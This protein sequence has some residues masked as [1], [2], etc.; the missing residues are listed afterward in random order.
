MK[1]ATIPLAEPNEAGVL[2]GYQLKRLWSR[3]M[4]QRQGLPAHAGTEAQVEQAEAQ[5]SHAAGEAARADAEAIVWRDALAVLTGQAPGA[6]DG[7]PVASAVDGI[8]LPPAQVAIGDPGAMLAR[9]PD[10]RAAKA[11]YAAAT[12]DVGEAEARRY[13]GISLLGLIGVGGSSVSNLITSGQGVAILMPR[14][15]WDF[16]DLGRVRAGVRNARA[17]REA[18]LAAYDGRVLAGL[19]DAEA[20]LARFGAAREGALRA[21][22]GAA[23]TEAIATLEQQRADAGVIGRGDAIAARISA[24]EAVLG[25]IQARE[26]LTLAYAALAKALGLGWQAEGAPGTG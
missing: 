22:E 23:H 8:P 20:A 14:L 1:P 25:A 2:G 4:R 16:P 10:I 13:P 6:L 26:G 21:R 15:T 18:A 24:N 3:V 7:L 11:A 9:R 17:E 19:Q 5:A 12:A